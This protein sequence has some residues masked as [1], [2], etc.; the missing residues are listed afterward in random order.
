MV[1]GLPTITFVAFGIWPVIWLLL[2]LYYFVTLKPQ[3]D[4]EE[5]R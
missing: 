1:L 3:K 2:A 4:E 5:R